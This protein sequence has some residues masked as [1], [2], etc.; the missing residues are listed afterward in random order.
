M[1]A[2][3]TL[4]PNQDA[5]V[6]EIFIAAPPTRVFQA[7]TDP[8]QLAQWWG[9][10]GLYRMTATHADVRVGGRWFSEGISDQGES[11][12][13]EGEYLEIDPPRLLAHTWNPSYHKLPGTVVRWELE[14]REVHGLHQQGPHRVGTGTL[15]RVTHSGFAGNLEAC[16]GH[17]DGWVRVL[18]WMQAFVEREKTIETRE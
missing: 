10:K 9:Q 17:G 1:M 15:V 6:V 5:V 16:K 7:L 18:G 4:T 8:R 2:T 12:R 11:F 3:A 14:S 13:V